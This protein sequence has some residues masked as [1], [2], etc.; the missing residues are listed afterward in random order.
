MAAK[1]NAPATVSMIDR[2]AL[3]A[4]IDRQCDR[5]ETTPIPPELAS[6]G[7]S[8]RLTSDDVLRLWH[9]AGLAS[10][11]G[12]ALSL[13]PGQFIPGFPTGDDDPDGDDAP[14]PEQDAA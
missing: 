10:Q 11:I 13:E 4:W 12:M 5:I 1:K 7:E 6:L 8:E 3:H 9:G 14:E 2:D